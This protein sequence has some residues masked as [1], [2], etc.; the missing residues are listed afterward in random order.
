MLSIATHW[1][2]VPLMETM[3]YLVNKVVIDVRRS[4]CKAK[5]LLFSPILTY[6]KFVDRFCIQLHR[7]WRNSSRIMVKRVREML[8]FDSQTLVTSNKH[9]VYCTTK[10]YKL[11]EPRG[12]GWRQLWDTTMSLYKSGLTQ[13][14][15]CVHT[16]M[17]THVHAIRTVCVQTGFVDDIQDSI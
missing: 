12:S 15:T 10:F 16:H 5:R 2:W 8:P 17:P 9:F 14:L 6:L 4:A 11:N 13:I 7:S 1:Y 3:V